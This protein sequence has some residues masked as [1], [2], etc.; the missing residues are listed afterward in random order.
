MPF[1]SV[2]KLSN[3]SIRCN[4]QDTLSNFSNTDYVKPTKNLIF[5]DDVFNEITLS[6]TNPLQ[7]NAAFTL[8]TAS[9]ALSP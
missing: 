1:F 9:F 4:L 8:L 2:I 5:V 3:I 6:T 7:A